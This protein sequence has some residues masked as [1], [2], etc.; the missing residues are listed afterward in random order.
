MNSQYLK[1]LSS[2]QILNA[3]PPFIKQSGYQLTQSKEVILR[4]IEV[5]RA[6]F[7]TFQDAAEALK[8][9]DDGSFSISEESQEVLSWESTRPLLLGWK[10]EVQDMAK[11]YMTETE[12]LSI[13][14]KLKAQF[15]VKGKYL[16]MPLRVAILGKPHGTELK[17]IVP[18]LSKAQLLNRVNQI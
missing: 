5:L 18:L 10:Q 7:E 13:Q 11:D 4:A 9:L 6:S 16:F 1:S 12:F 14:D 15:G 3:L 17:L 8:V 2:E